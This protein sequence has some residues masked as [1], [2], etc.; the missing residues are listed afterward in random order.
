VVPRD[1]EI[2]GLALG[3]VFVAEDNM[4][5]CFNALLQELDAVS[6]RPD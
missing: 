1:A 5:L 2:L 3:S 6:N 4:P